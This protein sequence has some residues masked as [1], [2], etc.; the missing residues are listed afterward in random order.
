[1]RMTTSQ[2]PAVSVVVPVYQNA[3]TLPE[4]YSR[5]QHVFENL[6]LSNEIIFVDDA[7]PKGS[8]AVLRRLVHTKSQVRILVLERNI[9]QHRAILMGLAH[10]KAQRVIVLD[11]DLQDPP[12]AIPNLLE[13]M[14]QGYAAVFAGR[15]GHYEPTGRSVTSRL[16]KRLLHHFAGVPTDAGPFVVVSR[17]LVERLLAFNTPAP[18]LVAMI[19]CSRQRV[20]SIPVTRVP[21]PKGR[22]GYSSS[23]RF[24]VAADALVFVLSHRLGLNHRLSNEKLMVNHVEI[25][26]RKSKKSY[27]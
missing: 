20:T 13:K 17:Q 5:L 6:H 3:D 18:H 25:R 22:S 1:M 2:T 9:G 8:L 23:G 12:E 7:C 15:L 14:Q 21:R 16:F 11:A 4:L 26:A 19:G 27:H 10:A 24:K